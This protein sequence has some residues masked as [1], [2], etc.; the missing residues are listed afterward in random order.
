VASPDHEYRLL[1]DAVVDYAIFML[2]PSGHVATWNPGAERIK[3]Y[4][5]A[6]IVGK[7][8]SIFYTPED[9]AAGRPEQA[10]SEAARE[11]RFEHTGF[12]VRRDGST[13]HARV[14]IT[15]IHDENGVLTGFAKVTRDLTGPTLNRQLTGILEA[16][17]D[18]VTVQDARGTIRY[19]NSA[20]ARVSGFASAAEMIATPPSQIIQRYELV[21]ESGKPFPV[22]RLPGRRA[23]AGE[24]AATA[25]LGVRE[26]ATGRETWS[27]IRAT[28]VVDDAGSPLAVNV[29]TD[30]T[31][32]RR[33]TE[34]RR[35]LYDA[36]I[37]LTSS[38][39]YEVTLAALARALVPH[40][41]DW[42]AIDVLEEGEVKRVAVA[43]VDPKKVEFAHEMHRRYP[44]DLSNTK[45]GLGAVLAGGPPVIYPEIT[46]EM[47][48]ASAIDEEHLKISRALGLRSALVVPLRVREVTFGAMTLI[49]AESPRRYNQHDLAL[50]DELGKRAGI[51]I[52]N[53]RLY[54]DA[55][56]A[57][58]LRDDFL[59]VAG[60]ELRTPLAALDLQLHGLSRLLRQ[61]EPTP[62]VTKWLGRV[63]KT[64][65]HSRRLQAL[66]NE[67]LD[68]G[69]IQRGRLELTPERFE[70]AELVREVI[71]RHAEVLAAAACTVD[72]VVE[73]DTAG[74]WD[75]GRLDQVVT[76]VVDNA[77]KYGRG[78]P[79]DVTVKGVTGAVHVV[80]RDRGIGIPEEARARIF[81]RFERAASVRNYGGL[82]LGLWITRQIVEAHRGIIR[83]DSAPGEGTTFTVELPR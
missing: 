59:S 74:S 41:A 73:G 18:G 14:I 82:G 80:V 5:A 20:A 13:F 77:A 23:L 51:A 39:D 76:N 37:T 11:G 21:D 78:K 43:H 28:R 16:L 24:A 26:K 47:L 29:W 17:D 63:D 6:E 65:Q 9:I 12:R 30:I 55:Q 27:H 53:A 15:A 72:L 50:A 25:V 10:L 60:H 75:R 45:Q 19:A 33:E 1:V 34:A 66:I 64:V 7:H 46:D 83:F 48:V 54:R 36:T 70:L 8:F 68:V 42:C 35:Y 3:G 49:T 79:I 32:E 81:G 40:L 71:D 2:D 22:E 4:S 67:L 61:A 57:I 62:D 44:P 52:E 38:L 69:R 56:E 58:Q 31:A